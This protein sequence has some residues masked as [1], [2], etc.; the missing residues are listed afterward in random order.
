M[1]YP[2][3]IQLSIHFFRLFNRLIPILLSPTLHFI[4]TLVNMV[5][6]LLFKRTS[7]TPKAQDTQNKLNLNQQSSLQL[8]LYPFIFM[9]PIG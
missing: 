3:T 4:V 7:S 5:G 9:A 2:L 1:T 8:L 6:L